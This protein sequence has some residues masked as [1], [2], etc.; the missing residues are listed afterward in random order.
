[1]EGDCRCEMWHEKRHYFKGLLASG[2]A[3]N[4]KASLGERAGNIKGPGLIALQ[5]TKR[6]KRC[7]EN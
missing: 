1:M 5:K 3:E 6:R 4:I 7:G 2:L